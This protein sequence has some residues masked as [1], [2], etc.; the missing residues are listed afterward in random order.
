MHLTPL[1]RQAEPAR[2]PVPAPA[3]PA[4]SGG[5][6]SVTQV[7]I[8]LL[9]PIGAGIAAE[10]LQRTFLK[11]GNVPAALMAFAGAAAV[12][13]LTDGTVQVVR[14]K[15]NGE[16]WDKG[17]AHRMVNG[18]FGGAVVG[19]M[20]L[21]GPRLQ[22][23]IHA[24]V[25]SLSPTAQVAAAS[26]GT[27]FIGA[28]TRAVVDQDTWKDGFAPGILRVGVNATINGSIGACSGGLIKTITT[29]KI[30]PKVKW[31]PYPFNA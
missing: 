3:A 4:K 19:A 25:P 27:G 7:A 17:V 13:S 2:R 1:Q 8:D 16:D 18:A 29:A 15:I 12:K 20:T 9:T 24:R 10:Q 23:S 22:K 6:L 28:G 26:F 5:G 21:L 11:R 31:L 14:N 30:L